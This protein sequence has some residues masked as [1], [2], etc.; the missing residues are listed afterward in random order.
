MVNLKSN[1]CIFLTNVYLYIYA[2][3]N[4]V[5]IVK[6]VLFLKNILIFVT[7]VPRVLSCQIGFRNAS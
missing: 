5:I 4:I 2:F 6:D 3:K 1:I 7:D